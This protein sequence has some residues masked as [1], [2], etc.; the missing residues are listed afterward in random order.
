MLR[1]WTITWCVVVLQACAQL[2]EWAQAVAFPGAAVEARW[3]QHSF[4]W[5][6][7]GDPAAAPVQ[8]FDDGRKTWLQ[9]LPGQAIPA[10]FEHTGAGDR[11]LDY[12]RQ[13]DY[14]ILDGVWTVLRF[15]GGHLQAQARKSMVSDT[16]DAR[17]GSGDVHTQPVQV[18][19]STLHPEQTV[20]VDSVSSTPVQDRVTERVALPVSPPEHETVPDSVSGSWVVSAPLSRVPTPLVDAGD[21]TRQ[22]FEPMVHFEHETFEIGPEDGNMREALYR[23][24]ARANWTFSPEHWDV[25]IDIPVSGR[26]VFEGDFSGAVQ[27]LLS[28]TELADRPLRPCFYSNRVLRVVPYAQACDRSGAGES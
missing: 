12:T 17:F 9:F 21:L 26:A 11:V 18:E 20:F 25:D 22:S 4:D 2:P 1:L 16:S 19:Q 5:E 8:V 27:D 6:L 10:V 3:G 14:L 24:A 13:G 15:R 23:W 28:T 7:S